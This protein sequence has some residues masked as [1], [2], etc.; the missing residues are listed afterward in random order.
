MKITKA[1]IAKARR[2]TER[3]IAAARSEAQNATVYARRYAAGLPVIESETLA[4]YT[5]RE[6]T[7]REV[8][9]ARQDIR[10]S[11]KGEAS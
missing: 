6:R 8:I 2:Q 5:D 3:R 1:M 7:A 9:Q 11:L 4:S 10:N